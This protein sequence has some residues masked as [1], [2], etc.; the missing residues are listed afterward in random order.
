MSTDSLIRCLNFCKT[1]EISVLLQKKPLQCSKAA[2]HRKN[3]FKNFNLNRKVIQKSK[4]DGLS[5]EK[6]IDKITILYR[7][8]IN[9]NEIKTIKLNNL[10]E[11]AP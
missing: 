6:N 8:N 10:L 4:W 3:C 5:E 9:I 11:E 7:E 2:K 1:A